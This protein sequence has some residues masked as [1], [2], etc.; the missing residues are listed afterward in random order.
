[1]S[2]NFK[3]FYIFS[4][5]GTAG[6]KQ[7]YREMALKG[8]IL[9]RCEYFYDD[10]AIEEP[11]ERWFGVIPSIGYTPND[12]KI[13]ED[14]WTFIGKNHNFYIYYSNTQKIFDLNIYGCPN[15][16][17]YLGPMAIFAMPV[18]LFYLGQKMNAHLLPFYW[19]VAI[20]VYI[21]F[22]WQYII[23]KYECIQ[24]CLFRAGKKGMI[25]CLI[26]TI[27]CNFAHKILILLL[28]IQLFWQGGR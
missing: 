9:K 21:G 19:I 27:I 5:L 13:S 22:I 7:F 18:C 3:V 16:E 14:G 26:A 24:N 20:T 2:K 6:T 17:R 12:K 28:F 1:M 8:R 4:C 10:Y 11:Q 25:I 15:N 23:E